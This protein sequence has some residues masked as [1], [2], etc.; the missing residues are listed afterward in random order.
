MMQCKWGSRGHDAM[1]YLENESSACVRYLQSQQYFQI[2]AKYNFPFSFL[3]DFFLN[4]RLPWLVLSPRNYNCK[5]NKNEWAHEVWTS[6]LHTWSTKKKLVFLW[7]SPRF[8]AGEK[9]IQLFFSI[10]RGQKL[11]FYPKQILLG[12]Y[13]PEGSDP[14]GSAHLFLFSKDVFH[15]GRLSFLN[16]F[17][18]TSDDHNHDHF[19]SKSTKYIVKIYFKSPIVDFVFCLNVYPFGI[20]WWNLYFC[21]VVLKVFQCVDQ[22]RISA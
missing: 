3:L 5:K 20:T 11:S 16:G 9:T 6:G 14:Y 17:Y 7:F 8:L 13:I 4:Q 12:H 19:S 1:M 10:N 21:G 2:T 22:K 18:C 15:L